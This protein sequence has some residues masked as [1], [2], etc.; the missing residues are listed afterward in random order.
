MNNSVPDLERFDTGNCE[1]LESSFSAVSTPMF[2]TKYSFFSVF[3]DLQ[4]L[5]SFAPLRSQIFNENRHKLFAFSEISANIALFK[6]F[7]SDFVPMNFVPM[8]V[9]RNFADLSRDD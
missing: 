4:D 5:Q 3:R 1:T 6:H 2:A 7:S 9:S 8:I